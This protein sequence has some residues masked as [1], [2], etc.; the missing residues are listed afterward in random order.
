MDLGT[1]LLKLNYLFIC[2][3]SGYVHTQEL[4][5]STTNIRFEKITLLNAYITEG[6]SFG[7]IDGDGHLDIIAGALWWK[8]PNFESSYAYAPIK[9]F[10][11]TGPGLEGYATNF[12]NFPGDFDGD[13]KTDLLLIG[14]PGSDGKWVKRPG[15]N[16][17]AADG[18]NPIE[19]PDYQFALKD[20]SHESPQMVNII[21][22][23][24]E[25]LLT[26]SEGQI[27]LATPNSETNL[28]WKV[29]AISPKDVKRFPI[30]SHGLGAGDINGNGLIDVVEKSGWWEQPKNWDEKTLWKFHEYNFTIDP[31]GSQMM[32]FDVDGDG[33]NDI[34]TAVHAHGYGLSW[35]EQ[36]SENHKIVFKKHE[37]MPSVPQKDNQKLSFSQLHALSA[38]DIDNDGIL[39]IVTGKCY[40]AHN[41]R[42]PG[43]E[44]PA[45]LYWFKTFRNDDG[46]AEFIP[47]LID[48]D[49]GVGRQIATGDVNGDGKADV[50]IA[51]KKGVFLFIQQ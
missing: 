51:N 36:R 50:A 39:D 3:I 41:G 12:F 7:D 43:A 28:P 14:I 27:I 35:Y 37:I 2:M 10:P 8:G 17:I 48:S 34:V 46:T 32:V 20:V 11:I 15:K 47:H 30:F 1:K 29:L 26:F 13:G 33:D 49:S 21:G 24:R 25:E 45:V 19:E 40:Y 42:D 31:G 23:Q 16:P 44:D 22:D 4:I 18:S 38:V 6:A 9:K 5:N